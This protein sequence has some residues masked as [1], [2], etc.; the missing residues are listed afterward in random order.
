MTATT[1]GWRRAAASGI[2]DIFP[3]EADITPG[4][5]RMTDDGDDRRMTDDSDDGRMTDDGGR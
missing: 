2:S 1:G 3:G 5:R 4:G